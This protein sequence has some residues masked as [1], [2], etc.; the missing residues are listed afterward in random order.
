MTFEVSSPEIGA[1]SMFLVGG[2]DGPLA[3][4][5]A[6]AR[7]T[8]L[9]VEGLAVTADVSLVSKPSGR[10]CHRCF[11]CPRCGRAAAVLR[12]HG[13]ELFCA[14]C[15]PHR[16][17]RQ[18]QRSTCWWR[19]EGGRETDQLLR[20]VLRH[21]HRSDDARRLAADL[22]RADRARFQALAPKIKAALDVAEVDL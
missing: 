4:E 10:S 6:Q 13:S 7:V 14:R 16:T 17:A 9:G 2:L 3:R 1:V 5:P 15:R 8:V 20:L 21:G 19:D 11:R 12:A 18:L 22:L